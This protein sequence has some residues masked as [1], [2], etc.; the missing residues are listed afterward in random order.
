MAKPTPPA[1]PAKVYDHGKAKGKAPG[2]HVPLPKGFSTSELQVKF[3][4]D[5][6]VRVRGQRMSA[7][8]A[9]DGKAINAVL[10]KYPGTSINPMWNGPERE[11]TARR[12]KLEKRTGRELPDMNSWYRVTVP[13]GGAGG[14]LTDLNTLPSVEFAQAKPPTVRLSE[15]LRPYQNYRNRVGAATGTGVDADYAAD[16]PGG[17]GEGIT[18]SD[19]ETTF[20]G[21]G[22]DSGVLP[23]DGLGGVAAG[24]AHTVLV[25]YNGGGNVYAT[26]DNGSGQLGDGSGTDST[27]LVKVSGL[28]GVTAV[29]AGR[30]HSL[31]L[32]SDGTVWAWGANADGQLGDGTTTERDAPV[33]VPG[34]A[35]AVAVAAGADHSLAVL[36]DGTVRAWGQ[37]A[38]GQ[39][40]DGTA[41]SRSSPVA[42]SGLTGVS[43]SAGSVSGGLA[44]SVVVMADG[45]VRAWGRNQYGQLG[46]GT[47]TDSRTPVTVTGL[48]GVKQVGAG[49]LHTLALLSDG[50]VRAAGANANGQLGDGTTTS[51]SIAVNPGLSSIETI[52]AGGHFSLAS[53]NV[54]TRVTAWAWGANDKGQL[55]DGTTADASAPRQVAVLHG[56]SGGYSG[57]RVVAGYKHSVASAAE[58]GWGDNGE[59]QL[60]NGSTTAASSPV[61]VRTTFSRFNS[62]HEE[63]TGRASPV[64]QLPPAIGDPCYPHEHPTA[65]LGI[66]GAS[67]DNGK[68]IAG[69]AP[70]ARLQVTYDS[71]KGGG[72]DGV[73]AGAHPGDVI[74]LEFA[75][76][77]GDR[78][79]PAEYDQSVYDQIV[80]ATA[81]G[82]TVVEP[83]GNGGNSLDDTTDLYAAQVMVRPD[84][85]AI[86]VGAGEPPTVNGGNC[87]GANRPAART[88]LSKSYHWW[89]S[90]YGGRVDVQGY[91]ECVATVGTPSARSLTPTETDP[92]KQFTY[93]N[94]TSSATPIVAGVIADLQGVAGK[95]GGVLAPAQVR[96]VLRATGSPQPPGDTHHIGPLP[97]LKAAVANLR[98]GIAGG[99]YHTVAARPDGTV[100]AW[101]RNG[102]GQLGDGTTTW[103]PSPVQVSGLTGVVSAPGAV[104]AG[105]RHSL[106]VRSD[107]TVWAW[108]S[109]DNGQLGDGTTTTR[110]GPVQV[111]GLTGVT[112]VAAGDAFSLALKSDGTVWAWGS[113]NQGQLGDGARTPTRTAP[114]QVSG[115]TD[116]AVIAAG[117]AHALAVRSDGT[118]RAWG[119][120]DDGQL[121]D[122]TTTL[123]TAP[124]TVSGLSGVSTAPGAIAAGR[125]H[126]LAAK[127][128]GTAVA[129]GGNAKG[130]LGNGS[131]TASTAPVAVSGLTDV[132]AVETGSGHSLAVKANGKVAAWGDNSDG[133]VGNGLSG[134]HVTTPTVISLTAATGVAGGDYQSI[135]VRADATVYTWGGNYSGQLGDGTYTGNGTPRQ[136]P[137][138]P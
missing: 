2:T 86:M 36:S 104:A 137:G 101:G 46:N 130:Q 59:G 99:S 39:L 81:A 84:S 123:R 12:E 96:R 64:V 136:V 87:L 40:G 72:F 17:K 49:S 94:G 45:T 106:A 119:M 126:S 3:R 6:T 41:T 111:T 97:N 93:Y 75:V 43:T 7:S 124:V 35:N 70:R 120:N 38:Y 57:D 85:G 31:A 74:F 78:Q 16:L 109:N 18:V 83:A 115:L 8:S 82:V 138:T 112:A 121:G 29:A 116:V 44:H 11:I 13:N 54:Q 33:Q 26:G 15:P 50:T 10:A 25:A 110:T 92:N 135:A 53:R 61:L 32:K 91:G 80:L 21:D 67:D 4:A 34:I 68:G 22:L 62:C 102:E 129:W 118:V 134:G 63:Y 107:G 30:A 88:A 128:D 98:G 133:Q 90:T 100:W 132:A 71:V 55:G 117:A 103:R 114:A 108:G 73:L 27:T 66:V 125:S 79:Y 24:Y 77:H 127:T 89:G 28:T 19:I 20:Q 23:R 113:G 9:D 122:G 131:T 5:K 76:P 105:G 58:W 95:A 47:T 69:V 42:V 60:G 1:S 48:S 14:L 56:N 52:A 51:R 65:T 37:N